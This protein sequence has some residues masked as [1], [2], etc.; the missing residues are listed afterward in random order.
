MKSPRLA[1]R[2]YIGSYY[3][4]NNPRLD[5]FFTDFSVTIGENKIKL[6]VE[7]YNPLSSVRY[8][9]PN[10]KTLFNKFNEDYV[11]QIDEDCNQFATDL[12]SKV[13]ECRNKRED[14]L[15]GAIHLMTD[16]GR[17]KLS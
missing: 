9:A 4:D 17:L 3:I 1:N 16:T 8:L 2:E 10:L 5:D 15:R 13:A 6:N 14:E 11:E 7:S 12:L